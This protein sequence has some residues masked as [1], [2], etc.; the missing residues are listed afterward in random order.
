MDVDLFYPFGPAQD[1]SFALAV[2]C[3]CPV[4]VVCLAAALNTG[5]PHGIWG[6][7]TEEERRRVPREVHGNITGA[8]AQAS[9]I[10][11]GPERHP[12]CQREGM[13]AVPGQ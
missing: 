6:G 1:M 8:F 4:R 11:Y 3:R 12:A 2:C 9:L 5:E 7:L 10:V 13:G